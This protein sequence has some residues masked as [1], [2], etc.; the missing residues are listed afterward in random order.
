MDCSLPASSVHGILQA[1][2]LDW[3]ALHFSR[4]CFQPRDWTCISC[5]SCVS[6]HALYH[7]TA[8]EAYLSNKDKVNKCLTL[9]RNF[10]LAAVAWW[11]TSS[12]LQIILFKDQGWWTGIW[13]HSFQDIPNRFWRIFSE[14]RLREYFSSEKLTWHLNC[15]NTP[16]LSHGDFL[17]YF[18]KLS[19]IKSHPLNTVYVLMDILL[20]VWSLQ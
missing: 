1:R 10:H 7:C 3:I 2:I 20:Y 12:I 14:S 8:W 5:V 11:V 9:R 19:I 6:R 4:G 17:L 16:R 13:M 18:L 15:S